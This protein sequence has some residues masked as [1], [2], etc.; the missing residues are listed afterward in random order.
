MIDIHAI[1]EE[2]GLDPVAVRRIAQD[3]QENDEWEISE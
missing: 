2:F 1:A 3:Q